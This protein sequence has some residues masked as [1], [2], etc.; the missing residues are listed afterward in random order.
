MAKKI[1]GKN[2]NLDLDETIKPEASALII[3]DMQN[4][5]CSKGGHYDKCGKNLDSIK[6]IIP[7]CIQAKTEEAG[8]HEQSAKSY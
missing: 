3:V 5:F 1:F 8:I 7:I 4:D 2:V 6:E